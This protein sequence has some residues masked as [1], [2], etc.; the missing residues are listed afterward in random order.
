MRAV[1]LFRSKADE[2]ESRPSNEQGLAS[3]VRP[4][5]IELAIADLVI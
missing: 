1:C 2:A 3:A 4:R 5:E